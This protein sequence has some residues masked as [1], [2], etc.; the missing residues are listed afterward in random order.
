MSEIAEPPVSKTEQ[1][2]ALL[3]ATTDVL[4]V[5]RT[6]SDT[7]KTYALSSSIPAFLKP[8]L[9]LHGLHTTDTIE[10]AKR[11]HDQHGATPAHIANIMFETMNIEPPTRS[12]QET[13][14]SQVVIFALFRTA[15][16]GW[17]E[18][19]Q[20]PNRI[21]SL[22]LRETPMFGDSAL[23]PADRIL[24]QYRMMQ[25]LPEHE[26]VEFLS[27]LGAEPIGF[28]DFDN[29]QRVVLGLRPGQGGA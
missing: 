19:L 16:E 27:R 24:E 4:Q 21:G 26:E 28:E 18:R 22:L 11:Q 12:F 5:S 23:N 2:D 6:F 8:F 9:G 1:V 29:L 3:A 14:R 15:H 13:Y 10:V 7:W 20:T 25:R 17:V